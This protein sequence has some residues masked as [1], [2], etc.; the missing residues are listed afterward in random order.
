MKHT[1]VGQLVKC[2][3]NILQNTGFIF[4]NK[5]HKWR[6][7]SYESFAKHGYAM[8]QSSQN[9][10]QIE[11]TMVSKLVEGRD[12]TLQNIGVLDFK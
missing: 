6:N 8:D 2:G 11:S 9:L 3:N 5:P 7:S 1:V 4:F 12:R 10:G